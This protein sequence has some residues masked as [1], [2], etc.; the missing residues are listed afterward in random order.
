MLSFISS[1]QEFCQ[2][3]S[4]STSSMAVHYA[5]SIYW[6]PES[7]QTI[8]GRYPLHHCTKSTWHQTI[9][10]NKSLMYLDIETWQ[11]VNNLCSIYE[12]ILHVL[13]LCLR[14]ASP[15]SLPKDTTHLVLWH[16]PETFTSNSTDLEWWF[17][18]FLLKLTLCFLKPIS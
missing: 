14:I 17:K 11:V 5:Q 15:M 8:I 2:C 9:Y 4:Y 12:Y 7:T 3:L 10:L 16:G 6:Y 18:T 1:R 13:Q